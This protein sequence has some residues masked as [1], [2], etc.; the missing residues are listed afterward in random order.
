ML[1]FASFKSL[2]C[3]S[4]SPDW[5]HLGT[6]VEL[7]LGSPFR[8]THHH[9]CPPG[10]VGPTSLLKDTRFGFYRV[11][12]RR[13]GRTGSPLVKGSPRYPFLGCPFL[14]EETPRSLY[15]SREVDS[16]PVLLP[17]GPSWV[18]GLVSS[19][20][21]PETLSLVPSGRRTPGPL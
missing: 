4:H 2:G 19:N 10:P 6:F 21:V 18:T 17:C 15:P 5:C 12:L 16:D 11:R 20:T 3:H 7:W 9:F 1:P 8:V 13:V 14:G